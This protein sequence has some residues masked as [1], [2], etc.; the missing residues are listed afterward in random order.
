MKPNLNKL[1]QQM[2]KMQEDMLNREVTGEAGAGLVKYTVK[3]DHQPSKLEIDDSLL[4]GLSAEDKEMLI[5]LLM[6][7]YIDANNKLNTG[8]KDML[9]GMS[10]GLPGG[11]GKLLGG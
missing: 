11:L 2:Q 4:P 8:S 10:A 1:M 3:G 9:S 6:S 5:D 7:A